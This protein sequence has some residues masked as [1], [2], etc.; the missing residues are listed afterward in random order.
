MFVSNGPIADY[1]LVFAVTNPERKS[2]GRLSCFIVDRDTEGFQSGKPFEKMGLRTLQNSELILEAC[3]VGPE[4]VLGKEGQGGMIFSEGMACERVVFFAPH[5]GVMA[6]VLETSCTYTR[7][8]QQFGQSVATFQS[9]SNKLADM[10]VNLELAR[11]ILYKTASQKD[12]G[13]R[14]QLESAICKLFV[15]ESLKTTCLDA[16]QVHGAYGYMS[17]YDVERNLRDSIAASLYSGTS[18]I[19]RN[20][21][22]KLMGC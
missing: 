6:R 15:S 13:E 22:A 7:D 10:K 2:L 11:L 1:V 18:E 14:T 8:R 12:A 16:V 3:Q 20:I 17:E 4:S 9:V 21:I 5:V 19:Q